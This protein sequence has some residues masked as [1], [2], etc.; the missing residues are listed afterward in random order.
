MMENEHIILM[1]CVYRE[2]QIQLLSNYQYKT[3]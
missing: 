3:E 1:N 2:S